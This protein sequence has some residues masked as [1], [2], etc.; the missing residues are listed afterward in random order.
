MTAKISTYEFWEMV[1]YNVLQEADLEAS[2]KAN[3]LM[4][5]DQTILWSLPPDA[6]QLQAKFRLSEE[7]TSAARKKRSAAQRDIGAADAMPAEIKGSGVRL[8]TAYNVSNCYV[9][10]DNCEGRHL[11]SVVLQSGRACGGKHPAKECEGDGTIP[12][13]ATWPNARSGSTYWK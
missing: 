7:L 3:K 1:P 12:A 10:P 13:D 2:I 11:C 4:Q 8:C 6:L 9:D 5:Q